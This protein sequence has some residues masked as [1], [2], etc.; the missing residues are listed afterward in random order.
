M[1]HATD[2]AERF[3]NCCFGEQ[4]NRC[5]KKLITFAYLKHI[6]QEMLKLAY[7]V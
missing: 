3:F 5:E 6:V 1:T 7:S 4:N 2:V